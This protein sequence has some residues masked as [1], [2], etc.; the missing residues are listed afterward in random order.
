MIHIDIE[1]ICITNYSLSKGSC[2]FGGAC[3]LP[4]ML[5]N[6]EA[7]WYAEPPHRLV[8]FYDNACHVLLTSHEH[9]IIFEEILKEQK[10]VKLLIF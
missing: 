4:Y 8:W 10:E 9:G 2:H 6:Q 3:Y 5:T 1:L 7:L